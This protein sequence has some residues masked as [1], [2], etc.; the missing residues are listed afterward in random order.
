[1]SNLD[2]VKWHIEADGMGLAKTAAE[3][4]LHESRLAI[5]RKGS[6]S[7]VL[8]GGRT[9][10]HTYRY[11]VRSDA[12]WGQW[13][14]FFGDERCVARDDPNRNDLVIAENLFDDVSI[15][16][17]QINHMLADAGFDV[18]ISD[19]E[20]KI[21]HVMPFDLVILGMGEDGHTASL[22]PGHEYD[23]TEEVVAVR[24]SPKPPEERI[25]LNYPTLSNARKVMIMVE[26]KSKRAAVK[27]WLAGDDLPVSRVAGLDA[28]DVFIDNAAYPQ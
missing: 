21:R 2:K 9:P 25:S 6:F 11:L 20:K 5:G 12:E 8:A 27:S 13:Q 3:H 19:Y 16:S 18:A 23:E 24:E 14:V 7:I 17:S 26:G 15:P 28:T 1:M 4:I 10:L 22:F